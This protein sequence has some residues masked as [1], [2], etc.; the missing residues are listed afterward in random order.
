[1]LKNFSCEGMAA[2]VIILVPEEIVHSLGV[3][4]LIMMILNISIG[5]PLMSILSNIQSAREV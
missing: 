4:F 2:F 5:K 3:L 1:M